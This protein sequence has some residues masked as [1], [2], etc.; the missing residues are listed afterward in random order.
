MPQGFESAP[1]SGYAPMTLYTQSSPDIISFL[2]PIAQTK[3]KNLRQ[4]VEDL[5][6]LCPDF[7]TRHEAS[8]AK[9]EAENRLRRLTDHRSNGG[10]FLKT[11]DPRVVEQEKIVEE[12]TAELQRLTDLD[13]TRSETW[14]IAG[15]LLS[16]IESWTKNGIPGGNVLAEHEIEMPK[17]AKG[18][19]TLHDALENRRRRYREL[20]G[21]LARVQ[22]CPVPLAYARKRMKEQLATLAA[23][24]V[25]SVSRLIESA[26]GRIEFANVTRSAPVL[27]AQDAAIAHWQDVETLPLIAYLMQ[28]ILT[29][30]LDKLLIEES[31]E[32]NALM[33]DGAQ[34]QC[35]TIAEDILS[36][37]REESAIVWE[38]LGQRQPVAF[39][40]ETDPRAVLSVKL[41]AAPRFN[42]SPGSSPG[43]SWRI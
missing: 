40:I 35:A 24:G 26:D 9:I 1:A 42:P 8:K 10:Y 29:A 31:D 13:S 34:R 12:K 6:R 14:R 43:M 33:P 37:E 39:R 4:H 32:S 11:G 27:M 2:P 30:K 25:P 16:N 38:L 28:D 22:A 36:T 20:R 15:N 23:Q 17:L 3:L 41:I 7:E 18:E 19:S 5:R 21:D